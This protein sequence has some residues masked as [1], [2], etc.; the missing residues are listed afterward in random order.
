MSLLLIKRRS[1]QEKQAEVLAAAHGLIDRVMD[2]MSRMNQGNAWDEQQKLQLNQM[3]TEC[4]I[5]LLSGNLLILMH[6]V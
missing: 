1:K 6:I 2:E 3:L 4:V 5:L